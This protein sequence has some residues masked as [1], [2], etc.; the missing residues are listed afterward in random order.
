MA[1]TT[2]AAAT[3][4]IG[5]GQLIDFKW[6]L[7]V[8]AQSSEATA[9]HSAYVAVHLVVQD[10]SGKQATHALELSLPEFHSFSKQIK[11]ASTLLATQ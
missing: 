5:V 6:K 7:G 4:M 11:D 3:E 2:A 8:T 10:P 9:T 1:T